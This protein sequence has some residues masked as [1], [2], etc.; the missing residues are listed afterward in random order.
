MAG[1]SVSRVCW[2][3]NQADDY[4]TTLFERFEWLAERPELG[5]PRLDIQEGYDCFLHP[6]HVVFYLIRKG[7]IDII[8]V[9]HKYMDTEAW[10]S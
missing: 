10:F 2:S 8:D 5:T 9:P 4:I 1:R 3:G 6:P 7:A